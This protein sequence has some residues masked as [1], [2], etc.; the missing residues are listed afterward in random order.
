MQERRIIVIITAL[1]LWSSWQ[2]TLLDKNP[3]QWELSALYNL[4]IKRNGMSIASR[5]N[6][7]V[8]LD[9][10]FANDVHCLHP[11]V[12]IFDMLYYQQKTCL[13]ILFLSF[14][15]QYQSKSIMMVALSIVSHGCSMSQ[16]MLISFWCF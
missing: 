11:R 8:K 15:Y 6:S 9:P 7:M 10:L 5:M 4:Q 1:S 3:G 12:E 14:F 16:W 13:V 2:C